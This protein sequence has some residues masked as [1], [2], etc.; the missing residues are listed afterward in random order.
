MGHDTWLLVELLGEEVYTKISV[1]TSLS[2][3]SDADDLAGT[4]LEYD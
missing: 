4:M 2:G 1:L 3:G